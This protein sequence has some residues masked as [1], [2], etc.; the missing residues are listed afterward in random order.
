MSITYCVIPARGGSKRIPRKN[1]KP[2]L[3]K[4]MI[5]W[6]IEKALGCDIIDEVIVSTDDN[7]II[8]IAQ[9]YG[10]HVPF[11]RPK[12]LAD[13][14]ANTMDVMNHAAEWLNT[15]IDGLSAICCLYPTA[16]IVN[17]A[18]ITAAYNKIENSNIDYCFSA[19]EFNYP[20]QRGFTITEQGVPKML[21]PKHYNT[22]S[23]DLPN[24]YH[25]CGQFYW[26]QVKAWLLKKPIFGLNSNIIKIPHWRVQDIDTLDDWIRA[27]A[28][29]Q[30]IIS[31]K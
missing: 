10:A 1:I 17:I 14:Y 15:N 24:A 21:F 3:G 29:M 4:P 6:S 22:R 25:D 7:E 26:G 2:F 31:I 23:Q 12:E 20:V 19:T 27:E 30:N 5:A 16:P 9:S 11:I 28:I 13:D 8:E 18:D